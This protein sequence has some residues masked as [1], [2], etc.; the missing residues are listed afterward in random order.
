MIRFSLKC[1]QNHS[2]DSWF[3]SSDAY[4]KLA[5]AGMLTCAECG[6]R[7]VEKSLMAPKISTQ[8]PAEDQAL[9]A[10]MNEA[11]RNLAKIKQ[12]IEANSDYVGMNFAHEARA[13]RFCVGLIES[14]RVLGFEGLIVRSCFHC[15]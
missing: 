15:C 5:K 12:E 2:F 13:M 14:G 1:S 4:E 8:S 7:A 11:E 3:Q 6:D 9:S 10:P